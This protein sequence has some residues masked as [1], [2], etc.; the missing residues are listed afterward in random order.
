MIVAIICAVAVVLA[1]AWF[2]ILV[3][4]LMRRLKDLDTQ[5]STA[6]ERVATL[7]EVLEQAPSAGFRA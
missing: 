6:R 4:G 5:L 7:N 3:S 2:G 1:L